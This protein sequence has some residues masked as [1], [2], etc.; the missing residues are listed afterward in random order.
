LQNPLESLRK[1]KGLTQEQLAVHAGVTSKT[2]RAIEKGGNAH[3]GTRLLL[4]HVL[5]CDPEDLA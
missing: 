3:P 2:V 5:E 1:A 4:S